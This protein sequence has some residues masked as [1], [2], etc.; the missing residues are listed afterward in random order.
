[1]DGHAPLHLKVS[2]NCR[3]NARV[4]VA[5]SWGHVRHAAK[6]NYSYKDS[7]HICFE[8]NSRSED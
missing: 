1:M 8:L 5:S 6:C 4:K 3:K 7:I 2:E